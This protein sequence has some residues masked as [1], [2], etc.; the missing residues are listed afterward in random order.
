MGCP[1]INQPLDTTLPE[2]KSQA[3][4]SSQ[5]TQLA[6]GPLSV[7]SLAGATHAPQVRGFTSILP[8]TRSQEHSE[9]LG[10]HGG[11][12]L[13]CSEQRN[14]E[15]GRRLSEGLPTTM[16]RLLSWPRSQSCPVAWALPLRASISPPASEPAA[17][18]GGGGG[19]YHRSRIFQ[20]C[21]VAIL[22]YDVYSGTFCSRVSKSTQLTAGIPTP[23]KSSFVKGL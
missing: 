8:Q 17:G 10:D 21:S 2:V 23:E 12:Q 19:S 6:S 15:E 20:I 22:W 11:C 14:E 3:F 18:E 16:V 13:L 7:S 9:R 4:L 1:W 5:K